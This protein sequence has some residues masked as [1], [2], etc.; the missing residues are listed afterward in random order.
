VVNIA[1]EALFTIIEDVNALGVVF[2]DGFL[3]FTDEA[4][5]RLYKVGDN[6]QDLAELL[7]APSGDARGIT[8]IPAQPLPPVASVSASPA[9][10]KENSKKPLTFTITLSR[11]ATSPLTIPHT[12]GGKAKAGKDFTPR[13]TSGTV[14]IPQGQTRA[15]VSLR[16]KNDRKTESKKTITLS[17]ETG[18]GYLTGAAATATLLDDDK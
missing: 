11:P 3:Y 12:I 7:I 4:N 8:L 16:M 1:A 9:K 17:V 15:T 14:V 18:I 5:N 13:N 2:A 6:G 10:I